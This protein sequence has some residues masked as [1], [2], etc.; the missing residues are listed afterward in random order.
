MLDEHEHGKRGAEPAVIETNAAV[1]PPTPPTPPPPFP[2]PDGTSADS[3]PEQGFQSGLGI[4]KALRK[5]WGETV[6]LWDDLSE[7]VVRGHALSA[8]ASPP[9]EGAAEAC[10]PHDPPHADTPSASAQGSS[11]SGA[12]A[13]AE[14]G[15]QG[16]PAEPPESPGAHGNPWSPVV[17]PLSRA[18][19]GARDMGGKLADIWDMHDLVEDVKQQ[20]DYWRRRQEEKKSKEAATRAAEWAKKEKAAEADA[21]GTA[22]HGGD[23]AAQH[24]NAAALSL[25]CEEDHPSCAVGIGV[26]SAS[27]TEALADCE[28]E[29]SRPGAKAENDGGPSE[30]GTNSEGNGGRTAS[31]ESSPA[32]SL[33]MAPTPEQCSKR[34]RRRLRACFGGKENSEPEA[35]A[36]GAATA[37]ALPFDMPIAAD[38]SHETPAHGLDDGRVCSAPVAVSAA[39]AGVAPMLV[40]TRVAPRDLV[41]SPGS[42]TGIMIL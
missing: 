18:I 11:T 32:R 33:L 42:D 34:G 38:I 10:E 14:A 22:A 6:K 19:M 23:A 1:A 37:D 5:H 41:D 30:V 9:A 26:A 3:P 20:R 13:T 4:R 21:S 24:Q 8:A 27:H 12:D 31:A 25:N 29:R 7:R 35:V 16:A 36:E 39:A 17:R 15:A 2:P 40:S 28:S